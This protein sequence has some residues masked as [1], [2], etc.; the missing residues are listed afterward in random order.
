MCLAQRHIKR[1]LA[2]STISHMG[3]LLIAVGLLGSPGL[4]GAAVYTVAHGL[5]K[6]AMFLLAGTLLHC[7]GTVNEHELQGVGRRY[8]FTGIGFVVAVVGLAGIP[9]FGTA[10]G[11]S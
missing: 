5:V 9:P 11:K 2:F 3:M 6:G 1:L 4:A 7:L 8:P 10:L